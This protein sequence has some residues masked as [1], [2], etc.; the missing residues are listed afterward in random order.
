MKRISKNSKSK[1]EI[2]FDYKDPTFLARFITDGGKITPARISK[3]S[4]TFQK[5]LAAEIKKA[6]NL[7][8]VPTGS[9]SYDTAGRPEA[10]SPIPFEI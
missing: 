5:K 3:M 6:R 2:Q 9:H 10:I 1:S 7:A 4:I 8:L